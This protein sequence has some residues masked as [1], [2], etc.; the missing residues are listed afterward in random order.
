MASLYK[1]LIRPLLFKQDPEVAHERSLSA[2]EFAQKIRIPLWL[3]KATCSAPKDQ[4]VQLWD[5]NFPNPIG[6]AAGMD[7]DAKVMEAM[8]DIGFGFVEVGTVTPEPQPGNPK[9]RLFRYPESGAIVNRMGFNN[10]GLEP[11]VHRVSRFHQ[12]FCAAGVIGINLGKQ[13]TTSLEKAPE[14]YLRGFQAVADHADYVAVNISSP[15]TPDLRKM[16][17]DAPLRELLQTLR[18]QNQYR[19]S[20]GKRTVPLLLKIAP[21][22]N[23]EGIDRIVDAVIEHE[24]AGIIATNTTIDRNGENSSYESPGGLS[25]RPLKR[26]STEV[27]RQIHR[28]TEGKLPIIGVGGIET[29]DDVRQ[30]LDAG[31]KLVQVYSGF[32]YEGPR[33]VRRLM[34]GIPNA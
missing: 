14:D 25:G 33:M 1:N 27:I 9:P 28:R 2:L 34:K 11:L 7:K 16:Q 30:K 29:A 23:G 12:K 19:Q 17:D 8:F 4:S 6:L 10:E 15:N 5:L 3:L 24:W 26:R 22:L 13:K 18:E 21:D 32:I 31:A 20:E